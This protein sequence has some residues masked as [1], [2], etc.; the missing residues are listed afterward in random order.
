MWVRHKHMP[1]FTLTRH[2]MPGLDRLSFMCILHLKLGG[3]LIFETS[4]KRARSTIR[5]WEGNA[6]ALAA[7]NTLPAKK[8]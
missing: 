3:Q 1:W 5:L 7:I 2:S 8:A 4:V 6:A